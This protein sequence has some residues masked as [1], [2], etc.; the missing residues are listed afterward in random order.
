MR[1]LRCRVRKLPNPRISIFSPR[2][3]ERTT[4]S[5]IV[6]TIISLS[7]RVSSVK[8]DT[9]SIRSAL[10][11]A[12]P[13]PPEIGLIRQENLLPEKIK[14]RIAVHQFSLVRD[15]FRDVAKD[16]IQQS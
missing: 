5:K 3:K 13:I 7:L 12:A 10:V 11:I 4:L 14:F 8:R 2:R 9:S 1:G 6:S 15:I 16:K